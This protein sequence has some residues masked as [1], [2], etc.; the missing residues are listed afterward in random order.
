M[1]ESHDSADSAERLRKISSNA[2]DIAPE[3]QPEW[4]EESIIITESIVQ[5][6]QSLRSVD[7][8]PP[9]PKKESVE[10][11]RII[12]RWLRNLQFSDRDL[13]EFLDQ[14]SPQAIVSKKDQLKKLTDIFGQHLRYMQSLN[15]DGVAANAAIQNA[16]D[17]ATT[18][19]LEVAEHTRSQVPDNSPAEAKLNGLIDQLPESAK[20]RQ[21]QSLEQLLDTM[22][23]GMAKLTG[24][25]I[26]LS[27][28]QR[29][30]A[31]SAQLDFN[32]K[33]LK[34]PEAMD[35]PAREESIELAREILRRLKNM[36][37]GDKSLAEFMSLASVEEKAA[38]AHQISEVTDTYKN[39]L[40]EAVSGNPSLRDNPIIKQATDAINTFTHSVK[41]MAAKEIPVSLAASM[42]ISVEA[43]AAALENM[44]SK[45]IDRLLKSAGD[46]MEK[47]IEQVA[48]QQNQ[49]R[50]EEQG[51][52]AAAEQ[53]AQQAATNEKSKKK[54]QKGDSKPR[55]SS[56]KGGRRQRKQQQETT[57]DDYV[58]KQGR[59]SVDAKTARSESTPSSSNSKSSSKSSDSKGSK[60]AG[61][62]PVMAGL[63]EADMQAIRQL[64]SSLRNIGNQLSGLATNVTSVSTNDKITPDNKTLKER[65]QD[66]EKQ[67][68][69]GPNKN[70]P[71]R[72]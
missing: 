35:D 48:Q 5:T 10:E 49:D 12:L 53:A 26:E 46:A 20:M 41:L 27:S 2:S 40:A 70:G 23:L 64:G 30:A 42:Q 36:T 68:P 61:G 16:R 37:F 54:R 43:D 11:A 72:I 21:N 59:F 7:T 57:A 15:P 32:T 52:E 50:A 63:K 25:D 44:Q 51:Q 55:S 71:S 6:A 65:L 1:D 13:E 9:E 3:P 60:K 19:A 18:I 47:A 4:L 8:L 62:P 14:G 22:E 45:T 66:R 28:Y 39:L 58:L 38:F 31:A 34:S 69:Q 29:L 56:G 17:A 67:K 24:K 33:I